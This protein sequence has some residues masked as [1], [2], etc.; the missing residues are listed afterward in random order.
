MAETI[1]VS[2]TEHSALKRKVAIGIFKKNGYVK[3]PKRLHYSNDKECWVV[4]KK[5]RVIIRLDWYNTE[6]FK[7]ENKGK[8][9]VG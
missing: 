9:V 8:K 2:V 6:V 4:L 5:G 1:H 7:R 3:R